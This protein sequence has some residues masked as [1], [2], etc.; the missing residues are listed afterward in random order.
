WPPTSAAAGHAVAAPASSGA[1]GH[2][3]AAPASSAAAGHAVAS[4][5]T[6]ADAARHSRATWPEPSAEVSA[7]AAALVAAAGDVDAF[8]PAAHARAERAADDALRRITLRATDAR[9]LVVAARLA[10]DRA[11]AEFHAANAGPR[12]LR[13][14]RAGQ[15]VG[16]RTGVK[17]PVPAPVRA[18]RAEAAGTWLSAHLQATVTRSQAA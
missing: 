9:E 12:L 16:T 13:A 5:A 6:P 18:Q 3:V 17:A 10:F 15:R 7:V 11:P 8:T 4:P 2:A 14:I 1:A